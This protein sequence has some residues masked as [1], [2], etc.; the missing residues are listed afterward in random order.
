MRF[1]I[2]GWWLAGLVVPSESRESRAAPLR[3]GDDDEEPVVPLDEPVVPLD[4]PWVPLEFGLFGLEPRLN[5]LPRSMRG[6]RDP[7]RRSESRDDRRPEDVAALRSRAED[8]RRR[9]A[10]RNLSL[11]P[12]E[13]P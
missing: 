6:R 1:A 7:E 4:E 11:K 9:R 2:F 10:A 5:P 12:V 8:K 13:A 3:D